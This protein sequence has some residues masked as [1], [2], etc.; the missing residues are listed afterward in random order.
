MGSFHV[1]GNEA[2]KWAAVVDEGPVWPSTVWNMDGWRGGMRL[3]AGEPG[4]RLLLC[5]R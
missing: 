3:E 2:R 1:A 4:R 5:K